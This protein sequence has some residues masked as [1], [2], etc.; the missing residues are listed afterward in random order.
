DWALKWI[1]DQRSIFGESLLALAAVEGI[2][3]SLFAR[4]TV[5]GLP[6]LLIDTYIKDSAQREYLF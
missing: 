6:T 5:L 1:T 2:F 4:L 3:F